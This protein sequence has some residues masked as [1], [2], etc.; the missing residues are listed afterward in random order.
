MNKKTLDFFNHNG[1]WKDFDKEITYESYKAISDK[2]HLKKILTM[3]VHFLQESGKG[4]F[5]EKEGFAIALRDELKEWIE[6]PT[7]A[8]QMKDVITYR[9]MDY[10]Q[11]RYK[12]GQC[13]E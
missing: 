7:F 8:E 4:F 3:P 12:N 9:T 2:E 6:N 10:Y 13:Y 5:I 11:R 1:N